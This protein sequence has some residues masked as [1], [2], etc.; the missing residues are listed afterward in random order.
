MNWLEI[1]PLISLL[2]VLATLWFTYR[3]SQEIG[4]QSRNTALIVEDIKSRGQLRMACIDRRLQAHQEAFVFWARMMK[5]PSDDEFLKAYEEARHWWDRN[6]LY[7]EPTVQQAFLHTIDGA[8]T[9]HRQI[10][11]GSLENNVIEQH[12]ST[13]DDF[14]VILF[15]AIQLPSLSPDDLQFIS[16]RSDA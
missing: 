5:P 15:Q 9:N 10:R 11:A 3:N 16:R 4:E 7:L 13:F 8:L 14:P 2:G 1:A 6:C 12:R